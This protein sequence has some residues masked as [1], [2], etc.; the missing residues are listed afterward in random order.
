M[1]KAFLYALLAYINGFLFIQTTSYGFLVAQVIFI[2]IAFK[3]FLGD[4][5]N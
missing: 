1:K 5:K 4:S 2:V 3:E